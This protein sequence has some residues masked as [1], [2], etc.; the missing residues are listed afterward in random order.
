MATADISFDE[1]V[2]VVAFYGIEHSAANVE[3][4]F[5]LSLRWFDAMGH[6]PNSGYAVKAGKTKGIPIAKIT[7]WRTNAKWEEITGFGLDATKPSGKE[8]P[9]L[10]VHYDSVLN[11][12]HVEF[13]GTQ[14]IVNLT[15]LATSQAVED[16]ARLLKPAYGIGFWLDKMQV[17]SLY[18]VGI[19]CESAGHVAVGEEYERD[20]RICRWGDI[21]LA[22]QVYRLGYLWEVFPYN[23]LSQPQLEREIEGITLREWIAQDAGRGKLS[24]I[25][26]NTVLWTVEPNQTH[27][28]QQHLERAGIIFDYKKWLKNPGR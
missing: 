14:S 26:E 13:A 11:G 5:D 18:V 8:G 4:F 2:S 10:T 22:K 16:A 1:L 25:A 28:V 27:E 7:N 15:R 17:P 6:K 24:S 21:G 9:F 23:L 3:A 20:L 19:Q 12:S